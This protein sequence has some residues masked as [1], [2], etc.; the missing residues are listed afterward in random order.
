MALLRELFSDWVGW[1]SF[2]VIAFIFVIAAYIYRFVRRQIASEVA[3][4]QQQQQGRGTG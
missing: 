2:L 4:M 1:L 3:Q